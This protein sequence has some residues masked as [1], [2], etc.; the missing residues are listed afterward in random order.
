ML[1]LNNCLRALWEVVSQWV[2]ATDRVTRDGEERF[3]RGA[4]GRAD[5]HEPHTVGALP[6]SSATCHP[7]LRPSVLQF[8]RQRQLTAA[9][10]ERRR[11]LAEW[12]APFA[13]EQPG[14]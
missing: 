4:R 8:S 12:L 9:E 2:A 5:A 14:R 11:R 6:P 1:R 3:D 13:Y 10:M 7:F